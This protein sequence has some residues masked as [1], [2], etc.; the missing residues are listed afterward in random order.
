[1]HCPLGEYKDG[2]YFEKVVPFHFLGPSSQNDCTDNMGVLLASSVGWHPSFQGCCE[3][4]CRCYSWHL[5]SD[6]IVLLNSLLYV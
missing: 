5:I 3:H 6:A 2:I 4:I 1:M